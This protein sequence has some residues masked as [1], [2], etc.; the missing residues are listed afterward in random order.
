MLLVKK[1]SD[2]HITVR[3]PRSVASAVDG[4]LKTEEAAIMGFDSKADL[5]T[6]A[7]RN[8]LTQYGYYPVK[9]GEKSAE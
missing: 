9:K 6:A 1:R 5:V 8:L 3:I 2:R 4:F 7:I